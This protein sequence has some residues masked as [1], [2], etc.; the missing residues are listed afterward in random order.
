[1]CT[2][3]IPPDVAEIEREWHVGA[4]NQ[5]EWGRDLRPLQYGPFLRRARDG[6]GNGL[7]LVVGQWGL[8]PPW[9]KTKVPTNSEGKRLSTVNARSEDMAAKPTFQSSWKAGRRCIIPAAAFIEPNWETLV[10]V[11]WVFRRADGAPWG[12]AGLWNAWTD[13]S[14]GEVVESYT[15]LT[16]NADAHPLMKR[17]HKPVVDPKTKQPL[18]AALQDKRSVI[19]IEHGN[20]ELWLAGTIEEAKALLKLTPVEMFDAAP[21]LP[22][23]LAP[24]TPSARPDVE[25]E[26][27]LQGQLL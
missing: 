22:V 10:H 17:M 13:L 23:A 5:P 24:S 1:M 3:Y 7:E 27:P 20:L 4:H 18:S 12:L 26:P 19:A 2:R 15:M 14:T 21:L 25:P 6:G 11:P 16:L 8:I 9:S